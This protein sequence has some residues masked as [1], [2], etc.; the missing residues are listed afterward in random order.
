MF[1]RTSQMSN[2]SSLKKVNVALVVLLSILTMG[3]Y[4]GYWILNRRKSIEAISKN[5][6]IPF[7][8][9]WACTIYLIISLVYKII[10]TSILTAYGM[11]IFDSVDIILSFYFLGLLYYSVFRIKELLENIYSEETFRPWM[12]V[13]FHFWYLQFKINRLE[14]MT[15]EKPGIE[16]A[17]AK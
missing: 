17:L 1:K 13:L 12:L 8:W 14:G 7:K 15:N 2:Q 16:Q 11:A 4:L 10:G 9:W 5:N 6:F 3:V